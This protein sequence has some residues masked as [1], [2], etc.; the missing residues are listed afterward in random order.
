M[1]AAALR[2]D[3]SPA[4][5]LVS[6]PVTIYAGGRLWYVNNFE[7]ESL[8]PIDLAEASPTPTTPSSRS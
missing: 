6:G 3:I 4:T 1:L 7:H 2:L 8:G 5:T